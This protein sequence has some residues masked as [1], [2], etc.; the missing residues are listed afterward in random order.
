[1]S[2]IHIGWCDCNEFQLVPQEQA[3]FTSIDSAITY[4]NQMNAIEHEKNADS[5]WF[6]LVGDATCKTTCI[7][8]DPDFE[9]HHW[10]YDATDEETAEEGEDV[11]PDG[12]MNC[13]HCDTWRTVIDSDE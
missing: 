7:D 10:M 5:E 11:Y 4:S 2:N 13:K 8:C 12:R 6:V 1:M 3:A 9:L